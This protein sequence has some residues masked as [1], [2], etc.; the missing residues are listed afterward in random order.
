MRAID[1]HY[2]V[3]DFDVIFA[4]HEIDEL[5]AKGASPVAIAAKKAEMDQ[6]IESYKNPFYF[7]GMTYVEIL[8]VG[9]IVSLF[10]A[11]ILKKN[12]PDNIA[13]A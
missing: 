5:I 9:I 4:R 12:K 13:T 1:Y 10:A 6:F 7:A 8:P 3:P 2:F 11:L